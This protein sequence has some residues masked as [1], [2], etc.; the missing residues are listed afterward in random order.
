MRQV[1][2]LAYI[3]MI[4]SSKPSKRVCPFLMSCGS[5]SEARSRGTSIS[6]C[7]RLPRIV[8]LDLPLRELPESGQK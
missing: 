8:F 2:P 7:Q 6:I 4:L 5:N 3:E 1:M